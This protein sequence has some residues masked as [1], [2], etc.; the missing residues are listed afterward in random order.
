[1]PLQAGLVALLLA[2]L[3]PMVSAAVTWKFNAPPLQCKNLTMTVTGLTGTPPYHAIVVPFGP[4]GTATEQVID[5]PFNSDQETINFPINYPEGAQFVVSIKD[6]TDFVANGTSAAWTVLKNDA[7]A[8]CLSNATS[9]PFTFVL[10]PELFTQCIATEI[11]WSSDSLQGSAPTFFAVVPNQQSFTIPVT[12]L[13]NITEQITAF[14]WAPPIRGGTEFT[15]VGGTA[16]G[17]VVARNI[18]YT[19]NLSYES[20]C[21]SGAGAGSSPAGSSIISTSTVSNPLPTHPSGNG[22]STSKYRGLNVIA[23]ACGTAA[24]FLAILLAIL[25]F[26]FLRRRKRHPRALPINLLDDQP[27]QVSQWSEGQED[28]R[29]RPF[30]LHQDPQTFTESDKSLVGDRMGYGSNSALLTSNSTSTLS[31]NQSRQQ[32]TR[33]PNII[34]HRDAGPGAPSLRGGQDT[35]EL[36]PAYTDV[37]RSHPDPSFS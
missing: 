37:R 19:V 22:G 17:L 12:N 13:T 18:S 11:L 14:Y 29:P 31:L 2:L 1:M 21:L 20:G 15:L 25:L 35:I 5:I 27:R 9:V 24:A 4:A 8:S 6:A 30:F 23:I 10:T 33:A 16:N 34:Q 26:L 36:P 7:D 3:L 32:Q 28:V